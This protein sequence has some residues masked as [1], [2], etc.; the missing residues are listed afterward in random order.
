MDSDRTKAELM[1]DVE[2]LRRRV[3][4]LERAASL[5]AGQAPQAG[6]RQFRHLAEGSVQGF[7]IEDDFKM[8]FAN[9]AAAKLFG[10]DSLDDFMGIDSVLD[11]LA[12]EERAR[13][14]E[15]NRRRRAQKVGADH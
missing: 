9:R 12:H 3:G 13:A 14:G 6:E 8:L 11:L 7:Y 5:R 4:D 2:S 1:A 10:Y 15:V